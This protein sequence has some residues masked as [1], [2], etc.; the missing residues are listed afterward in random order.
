[1]QLA[2]TTMNWGLIA[3]PYLPQSS[4]RP[5][6]SIMCFGIGW[7][8]FGL[9]ACA[10]EVAS[11]V[12]LE[13]ALLDATGAEVTACGASVGFGQGWGNPARTRAI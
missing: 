6:T 5:F 10:S 3:T 13:D 8:D 2:E 7:S 9:S 4:E 11:E 1:M 12:A